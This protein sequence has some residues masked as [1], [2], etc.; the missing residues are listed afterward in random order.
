MIKKYV[1]KPVE[2][3]AIQFI[4][5]AE[6]IKEIFD[7]MQKDTM[8]V[9]YSEVDNPVILIET[10]G[11]TMK[12]EVGD[13]II[14]G[15][16]GE[17]YPCKYYIFDSTYKEVEEDYLKRMIDEEKEL[18][19]KWLSLIKFVGSELYFK[20]NFYQQKKLIEQ[21]VYMSGYLKVLRERI[22]HEKELRENN[23]D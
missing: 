16:N 2:I 14:K 6:R 22:K 12:A 15:V 18:H 11:G 13:Y 8:K 10:F 17:F 5:T 21:E 20:L 4:D 19:D 7:F 3:E 1:K 9:D 23:E